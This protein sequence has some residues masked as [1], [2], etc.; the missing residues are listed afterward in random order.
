MLDVAVACPFCGGFTE[1][2]WSYRLCECCDVMI[3]KVSPADYDVNYYYA[4]RNNR[5]SDRV[6]ELSYSCNWLGLI[7]KDPSVLILG[8]TMELLW[9]R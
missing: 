3:S 6:G 9:R 4:L 1:V 5:S 2:V 8:A 7:W